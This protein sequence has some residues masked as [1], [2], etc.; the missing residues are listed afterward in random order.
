[1]FATREQLDRIGK[2][3]MEAALA[4]ARAQLG[5]FEKL[6]S[7]NLELTR[8]GFRAWSH[9]LQALASTG[10]AQQQPIVHESNPR[11]AA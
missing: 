6:A 10:E 8:T 9:T 11:K 4:I 7:L 1:M 3:N 2:E 5:A